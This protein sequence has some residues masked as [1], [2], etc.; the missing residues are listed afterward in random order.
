MFNPVADQVCTLHT[1]LTLQTRKSNIIL[2][3]DEEAQINSH[4]WLQ[5]AWKHGHQA[6]RKHKQ[7]NINESTHVKAFLQQR[8]KQPRVMTVQQ[9][10]NHLLNLLI[11]TATLIF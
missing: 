3:K 7:V 2:T 5:E 10:V 11:S 1:V 6:G 8:K 9:D 4:D